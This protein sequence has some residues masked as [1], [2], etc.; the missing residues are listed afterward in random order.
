MCLLHLSLC[1]HREFPSPFPEIHGADGES[2]FS[3]CVL[4]V[5]VLVLL[6]T[7]HSREVAPTR[8][9]EDG[10]SQEETLPGR[11]AGCLFAIGR[12]AL[13]FQGSAVLAAVFTALAEGDFRGFP[14]L[15]YGKP[16]Q[17]PNTPSG[18]GPAVPLKC[19]RVEAGC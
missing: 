17:P 4:C 16:F 5:L 13:T 11:A 6:P 3:L 19:Q 15:L 9:Q 1:S 18:W 14:Y 7:Q 12:L 10:A 8:T 2:F